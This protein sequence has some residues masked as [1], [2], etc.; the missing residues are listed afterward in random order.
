MNGQQ[1]KAL[2][3]GRRR[4]TMVAVGANNKGQ[5]MNYLVMIEYTNG[6]KD[7][8]VRTFVDEFDLDNFMTETCDTLASSLETLQVV[9]VFC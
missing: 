3:C 2:T 5:T 8:F 6:Q 7:R 9:A 4:E 1:K